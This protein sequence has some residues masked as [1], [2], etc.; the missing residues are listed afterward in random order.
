MLKGKEWSEDNFSP[1]AGK[2]D[3]TGGSGGVFGNYLVHNEANLSS[4]TANLTASIYRF[5]LDSTQKVMQQQEPSCHAQDN[6]LI[7]RV[8]LH[9]YTHLAKNGY[10][11]TK[12]MSTFIIL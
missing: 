1:N 10:L 12:R 6:S 4:A 3:N 7:N 11:T 2:D 5:I 9:G 8:E